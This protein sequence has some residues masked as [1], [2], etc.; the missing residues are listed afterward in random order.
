MEHSELGTQ[1]RCH[2]SLE[3]HRSD[4]ADFKQVPLHLSRQPGRL[5][6]SG[7]EPVFLL[8]P[9]PGGGQ[10]ILGQKSG[11]LS[12]GVGPT[13]AGSPRPCANAVTSQPQ[14]AGRPR[15]RAVAMGESNEVIYL[16][17]FQKETY[18]SK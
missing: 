5:L 10:R 16:K 12:P 13:R 3:R 17:V 1:G 18:F 2:P 4:R 7:A 8:P 6:G 9:A 14:G 15:G 11:G